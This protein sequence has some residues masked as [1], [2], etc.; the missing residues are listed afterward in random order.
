MQFC[1]NVASVQCI[2]YI[3]LVQAGWKNPIPHP[4]SQLKQSLLS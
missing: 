1:T 2:V 3:A 4:T